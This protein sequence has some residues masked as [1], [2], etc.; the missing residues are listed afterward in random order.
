M[1]SVG[2]FDAIN[3]HKRLTPEIALMRKVV[4]SAAS[5]SPLP[6]SSARQFSE[7]VAKAHAKRSFSLLN[8]T[9]RWEQKRSIS[10]TNLT[11]DYVLELERLL[12][13]HNLNRFKQCCGKWCDGYFLD[14]TKNCS[15]NWC[16]QE[17]CEELRNK[18]KAHTFYN[19]HRR[20]K[21]IIEG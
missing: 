7:L 8:G 21:P 15:R 9:V 2:F 11:L 10:Q 19:R 20:V 17:E 18:A 12:T 16:L 4:A 13:P 3:S 5:S 14:E 6:Q 1:T